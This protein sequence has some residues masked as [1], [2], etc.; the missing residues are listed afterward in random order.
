MRTCRHCLRHKV[1]RPRGLCYGCYRTL[2]VRDMYPLA[3]KFARRG[4]GLVELAAMPEP[5]LPK[6]P[7][8]AAPGTPEKLA[9]MHE[10]AA[11]GFA[12]FHPA[13]ARYAGDPRPLATVLSRVA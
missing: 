12:I 10:R 1:T 2:A 11:G 7:T 6:S 4:L 8:T 13:D 5:P 3:S 9:V